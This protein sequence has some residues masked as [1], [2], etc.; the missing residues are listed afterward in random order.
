MGRKSICG[1]R[2]CSDRQAGQVELPVGPRFGSELFRRNCF[3]ASTSGLMYWLLSASHSSSARGYVPSACSALSMTGICGAIF[4]STSHPRIGLNH[5]LYRRSTSRDEYRICPSPGSTLSLS[6]NLGLSDGSR[7]F[8]INDNTMI[9]FDN[10]VARMDQ[11]SKVP[12]KA[13]KE[14][15]S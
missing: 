4:R 2:R 11:V 9:C 10:V 12:Q 1:Q 14:A 3:S 5:R 15:W 8:D 7:G 13:F 6:T